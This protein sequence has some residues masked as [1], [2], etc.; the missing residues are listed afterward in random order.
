MSQIILLLTLREKQ[1]QS[2]LCTIFDGTAQPPGKICDIYKIEYDFLCIIDL[3]FIS[4]FLFV[5]LL[6]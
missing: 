2:F 1:V 4:I 3:K 5:Q 6:F